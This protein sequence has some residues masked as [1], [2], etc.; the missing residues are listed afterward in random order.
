MKPVA[1]ILMGSQ[2]Y[3][4]SGPDSDFDYKLLMMPDF[5]DFYTYHKVEKNDLPEGYD[6]EHNSVMSVLTFDKNVR[7][8]NINAIELVFSKYYKSDGDIDIY[9]DAAV[10]A[11]S[12]G[13][14]FIVWDSFMA[15]V[16]GMI[17]N[18]LDR[19]GVNRKSA[20]RAM[21]LINLCRFVAEHDFAMD[22]CTWGYKEV[23]S[24]ARELRFNEEVELP[25]KEAIFAAF[26]DMKHF[27][28]DC[29]NY[30]RLMYSES[31]LS[32]IAAWDDDLANC[33]KSI[34]KGYLKKEL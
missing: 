15:T 12:E 10:R 7:K 6:P 19:Y 22:R 3:R 4:L 13:Y 9:L 1:R 28:D 18:S 31:E 14:I 34:V 26:E 5:N 32:L 27:A 17:K 8:G 25:T 21:Y 23:F 33:M 11:Y 29:R 30:H 2:N 20:S 24:A 16:E